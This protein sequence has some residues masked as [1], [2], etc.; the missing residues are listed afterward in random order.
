MVQLTRILGVKWNNPCIHIDHMKGKKNFLY[1]H[2]PNKQ[3][4]G[5]ENSTYMYMLRMPCLLNTGK[6]K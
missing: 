5:K 4:K 3:R 2:I 1:G 6:I